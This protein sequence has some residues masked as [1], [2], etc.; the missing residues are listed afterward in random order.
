MIL[1]RQLHLAAETRFTYGIPNFSS[2]IRLGTLSTTCSLIDSGA[3]IAEDT[4][5]A[6]LP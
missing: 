3:A 2:L 6:T 4:V 5:S 1:A